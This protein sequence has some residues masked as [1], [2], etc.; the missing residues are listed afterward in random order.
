MGRIRRR[1]ETLKT[2]TFK[3]KFLNVMFLQATVQESF[4]IDESQQQTTFTQLEV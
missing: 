2:T 1:A 3:F 4:V